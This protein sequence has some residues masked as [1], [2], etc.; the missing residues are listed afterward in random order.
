MS[1]PAAALILVA[2]PVVGMTGIYASAHLPL[3]IASW[4]P[5]RPSSLCGPQRGGHIGAA[6]P[7]QGEQWRGRHGARP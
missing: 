3:N 5:F 7:T 4:L 1:R 6:Q 2:V